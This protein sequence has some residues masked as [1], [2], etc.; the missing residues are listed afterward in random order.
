[1]EILYFIALLP[2]SFFCRY[3]LRNGSQGLFRYWSRCG[4]IESLKNLSIPTWGPVRFLVPRTFAQLRS[5]PRTRQERTSKTSIP[6]TSLP[7]S[8]KNTCHQLLDKHPD[9]IVQKCWLEQVM[10]RI[11]RKRIAQSRIPSPTCEFL[12]NSKR[13]GWGSH[14]LSFFLRFLPDVS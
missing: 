5:A 13:C 3:D 8:K 12:W 7:I 10:K 2:N 11:H 6:S 1:M 4:C 9:R 14:T